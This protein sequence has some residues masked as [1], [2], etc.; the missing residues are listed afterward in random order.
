L[1][2]QQQKKGFLVAEGSSSDC[3]KSCESIYSSLS[4]CVA[5]VLFEPG[6]VQIMG[7][8]DKKEKVDKKVP[9]QCVGKNTSCKADLPVNYQRCMASSSNPAKDCK[10]LKSEVDDCKG[11]PQLEAKYLT[12]YQAFVGGCMAQL[13][14]YYT[15]TH[16][17]AGVAVFPGPKG[18]KLHE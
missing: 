15:G 13:N 8:P 18:C 10:A 7:L 12:Q 14:A 3:M 9:A 5:T 6:K 4:T 2:L 16:P 11:C 17:T 1:L